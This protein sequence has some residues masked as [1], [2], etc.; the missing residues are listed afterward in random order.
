MASCYFCGVYGSSHRRT[1]N[2]GYS[3]GTNSR[4]YYGIRTLCEN[5]VYRI[6]RSNIINGIIWR[7]VIAIILIAIITHLK[8]NLW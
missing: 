7:Y 2:T 6:D 1:V 3:T 4:N 8:F 5:C